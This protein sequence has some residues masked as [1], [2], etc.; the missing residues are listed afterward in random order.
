MHRKPNDE[1]HFINEL[2]LSEQMKCQAKSARYKH[3]NE[4]LLYLSDLEKKHADVIREI[5]NKLGTDVPK[6]IPPITTEKNLNLFQALNRDL[7]M[8]NQDYFHY[9]DRIHEAEVG[10]YTD[11]LPTLNNLREDEEKHRQILLSILLRLNP[12]Q[13]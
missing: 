10:G 7:E 13:V 2:Q 5:L 12:H 1:I 4:K 3:F 11:L 6:K 8:N 9:Y